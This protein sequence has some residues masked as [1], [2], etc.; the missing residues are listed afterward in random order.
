VCHT[1]AHE[2][3][4]RGPFLYASSWSMRLGLTD[5]PSR[6]CMRRSGTSRRPDTANREQRRTNIATTP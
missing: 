4:H 1:F 5:C 6:L 2:T 3:N